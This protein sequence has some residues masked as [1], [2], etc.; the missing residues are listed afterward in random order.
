MN[1]MT[2][3]GV[4]ITVRDEGLISAGG[5]SVGNVGI[6]GESLEGPLNEPQILNS[7]ADANTIFGPKEGN[8]YTDEEQKAD[9]L[10]QSIEILFGNGASTVYA[11]RAEPDHYKEALAA[12]EQE[13]INI[14]LI[15]GKDAGA[16]EVITLLQNH[17]NQTESIQRE[18][19]GIIGCNGTKDIKAI[20]N[21]KPVNDKG[22]LIYVAPG[23][24]CSQTDP[25]TG[26]KSTE[27]LTG[28][29]TAAAVAGTIASLPVQTSPTNKT[30]NLE[31]LNLYFNHGQ[32]SN[33]VSSNILVIEKREGYRIVKGVTTSTN[34]AWSQITTRRIVDKATYGVRAACNPYIG[35]LNNE[36]IRSAMKA[37]I[38]SFL[39][40]MVDEEALTGYTLSVSATRSQ[41]I[42]GQAMVIMTVQP[43]FSIDYIVVT[44]NLG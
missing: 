44:M 39:T 13:I 25:Q 14:V 3:P 21:A 27:A 32:L 41:E 29:Y 8:T 34:I 7:I 35:K 40:R 26:Q 11:V 22:R 31:G 23:I 37:T 16:S 5:V 18:R 1:E 19:I 20:A 33:L 2:L 12:L 4:Y 15:A 42:S 43:T 17:L 38:D 9:L 30:L 24:Q 6:V 10:I 28:A 36:R